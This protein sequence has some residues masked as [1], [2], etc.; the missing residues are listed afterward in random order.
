MRLMRRVFEKK[1]NQITG[2]AIFLENFQGKLPAE[3]SL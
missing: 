2:F 3:K 1:F